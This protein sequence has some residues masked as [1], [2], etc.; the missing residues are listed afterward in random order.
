MNI[1]ICGSMKF[2]EDIINLKEK[3]ENKGFN[4]EIP[5]ECIKD[6]PKDI[7]SRAHFKRVIS[8]ETDAILVVNNKKENVENYI[9]ANTFAEIAFAYYYNKKIY[10]LN[11]IYE[12]F[13]DELIGWKAIT[14]S[15]NLDNIK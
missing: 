6:L 9:G 12:P 8:N 14:L 1:V 7:A 4:V 11:D 13:K 3:L 10:L 2:K 15:G 5:A